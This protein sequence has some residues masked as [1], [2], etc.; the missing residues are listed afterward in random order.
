MKRI[1]SILI[2]LFAAQTAF[3]EQPAAAPKSPAPAPQTAV[4]APAPN[5]APVPKL[6]A[7]VN[8]T[9]SSEILRGWPMIL[10]TAVEHP[11]PDA[12]DAKPIVLSS[13]KGDWTKLVRVEATDSEGV[14]HAWAFEPAPLMKPQPKISLAKGTSASLVYLLSPQETKKLDPGDYQISAVIKAKKADGTSFTVARSPAIPLKVSDHPQ[15][16]TPEQE[17]ARTKLE[18]VYS[19]LRGDKAAAEQA[20]TA[21]HAQPQTAQIPIP[22]PAQDPAYAQQPYPQ[23]GYYAQPAYVPAQSS[24]A[25]DILGL[26]ASFGLGSM[27]SDYSDFDPSSYVDT[28]G[29]YDYQNNWE[30]WSDTTD[31]Q[32]NTDE[33]ENRSDDSANNGSDDSGNA[34]DSGNTDNSGDTDDNDN[35]GDTNDSSDTDGSSDSG[36]DDATERQTTNEYSGYIGPDTTVTLEWSEPLDIDIWVESDDGI[37]RPETLQCKRGPGK[38]EYRPWDLGGLEEDQEYIFAAYLPPSQ[39]PYG[40]FAKASVK[41]TVSNPGQPDQVFSN[42]LDEEK[43]EDF[44]IAFRLDC[45]TGQATPIDK[46]D[47]SI[48]NYLEE[49]G[50]SRG[51]TDDSGDNGEDNTDD[52]ADDS[53]D[54]GDSG[55]AGDSG[56]STD[57]GDTGDAGAS[58]DSSGDPDDSADSDDTDDSGHTG[59][60]GDSDE[61]DQPGD[62]G[63][64]DDTAPG[65]GGTA[66]PRVNRTGFRGPDMEFK[67]SWSESVDVDLWIENQDGIRRSAM[68][69]EM[70]SIPE[71]FKPWD[72]VAEAGDTTYYVAALLKDTRGGQSANLTLTI[73]KPDGSSQDFTGTVDNIR[74][75]NCWVAVKID[76]ATGRAT[77][78]NGHSASVRRYFR[79]LTD[80]QNDPETEVTQRDFGRRPAFPL[81][82]G[83]DTTIGLS[84][85]SPDASDVKVDLVIQNQDGQARPVRDSD[86][87]RPLYHGVPPCFK[88]FQ[89]WNVREAEFDTKYFV[90]VKLT[91]PRN[92]PV[93]VTLRVCVPGR[94]PTRKIALL[95]HRLYRNT[96]IAFEVDALTGNATPI[97]TFDAD[98][99]DAW[100]S[101]SGS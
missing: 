90:A 2:L 40:T 37:R 21:V 75:K 76:C 80:L 82:H 78:I 26:L 57:T 9:T 35:F 5:P 93:D 100:R 61:A 17:A 4:Q 55:D 8:G 22:A 51:D 36:A 92:L 79:E 58:D 73:K 16:L 12:P 39:L 56:D 45:R 66:T 24:G 54:S 67:L 41:Y 48:T 91:D 64:A 25:S 68:N 50:H 34:G 28:T 30:D 101:Q 14:V 87:Q 62:S 20:M 94:V 86:G 32:G 29:D 10:Q 69:N 65:G 6:A 96:W 1:T 99:L 19:A 33:T 63:N 27:G 59:D 74:G 3:A 83:P 46:F 97:N 47:T 60:N 31:N 11:A 7:F 38:E 71:V 13:K 44:W 23:E 18:A 88:Y 52:S 42:A 72:A 49:G 84:W 81:F 53:G 70:G 89:P 77:P 15:T 43:E 98:S 85:F 95:D